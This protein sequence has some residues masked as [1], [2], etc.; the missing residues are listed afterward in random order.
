MGSALVDPMGR[1]LALAVAGSL[2]AI[3]IGWALSVRW[4][5]THG[6]SPFWLLPAL[7]GPVVSGFSAKAVFLAFTSVSDVASGRPLVLSWLLTLAIVIWPLLG[8]VVFVLGSLLSRLPSDHLVQLTVSGASRGEVARDLFWPAAVP[9]A[10]LLVFFVCA[11]T[12]MESIAVDLV[13]RTSPGTRTELAAHALVRQYRT[14]FPLDPVAA[15]EATVQTGFFIAAGSITV[16]A[17][18]AFALPWVVGRAVPFVSGSGSGISAQS[19][20]RRV[21]VVLY[22]AP[23][24]VA[25][26]VFGWGPLQG[27]VS[28]VRSAA[29]AALAGLVVLLVSVLAGQ[30]LSFV[31][32]LR[33]A[34]LRFLAL[35]VAALFVP[36]FVPPI[37]LLL[38]QLRGLS[39]LGFSLRLEGVAELAWLLGSLLLVGPILCVFAI[40]FHLQIPPRE[41]GLSRHAG[42]TL[43]EILRD[44]FNRRFLVQYGILALFGF[45]MVW[46]EAIY[47][48][49]LV[50]FGRAIP[51]VAVDLLL[52]ASGRAGSHATAA[53]LA[54]LFLLPLLLATFLLQVRLRAAG[55]R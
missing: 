52:A 31:Q 51:S 43:R 7:A 55:R 53:S 27:S 33:G 21:G 23:L 6:P 37:T 40:A 28:L 13:L 32:V 45:G 36:Y 48:S 11:R 30:L 22:L 9:L 44:S 50:G 10:R 12:M 2:L 25:P 19:G 5:V 35:A 29:F 24:G 54:A 49:L 17:A 8:V 47:A 4:Y 46:A 20:S 41:I 15:T 26:L 16:A 34:S 14:L 3:F 38:V 42:A 18:L 1:T 39:L